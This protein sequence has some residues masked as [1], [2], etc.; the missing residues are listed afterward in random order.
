VFDDRT[1]RR[2][3]GVREPVP[4]SATART[5][6]EW[7]RTERRRGSARTAQDPR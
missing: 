2:F 3:H 5:A 7:S 6:C 4:V 1:L